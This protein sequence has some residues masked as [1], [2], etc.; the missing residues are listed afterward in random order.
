MGTGPVPDAWSGSF[1]H[2][3]HDLSRRRRPK[4]SNGLIRQQCVQGQV[5]HGNL[6]DPT[7]R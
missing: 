6:F 3:Q 7:I 1:N 5:R 2:G 4:V